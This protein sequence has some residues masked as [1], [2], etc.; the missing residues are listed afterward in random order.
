MEF[1]PDLDSF[2]LLRPDVIPALNTEWLT[3]S[4]EELGDLITA[5][6]AEVSQ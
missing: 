6:A 2:P 4:Q 1:T 5:Y 3:R